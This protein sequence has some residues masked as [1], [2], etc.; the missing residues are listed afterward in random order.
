[1]LLTRKPILLTAIGTQSTV[2]QADSATANTIFAADTDSQLYGGGFR[3]VLRGGKGNDLLFGLDGNDTLSGGAGNDRLDGG[4]GNDWLDGG[5]GNDVLTG[6]AGRDSFAFQVNNYG[7][8]VNFSKDIGQDVVT[9]FTSGEDQIDLTS[10]FAR[11]KDADVQDII[12][13]LTIAAAP[14]RK[15]VDSAGVSD[16]VR[17]NGDAFGLNGERYDF[18]VEARTDFARNKTVELWIKNADDGADSGALIRFQNLSGFKAT[19]FLRET[20]K[21]AQG[22]AAADTLDYSTLGGNKGV[23]VYGFAGDD[24]LIGTANDDYFFGDAGADTIQGGGGS[25]NLY[26]SGSGD[27]LFGDGGDD[28]LYGGVNGGYIDGKGKGVGTDVLTGGAGRDTFVFGGKVVFD[29]AGNP[30]FVFDQGATVITDFKAGEDRIKIANTAGFSGNLKWATLDYDFDA[31]EIA[32]HLTVG[33]ADKND[34]VF[35]DGATKYLLDDFFLIN[36]GLTLASV[37]AQVDLYFTFA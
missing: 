30:N 8:S 2:I 14:L 5:S 22:T 27:R 28:F 31:K 1:M 3:D 25:D 21:I 16:P 6:G 7:A 9:D 37:K 15:G 11:F 34:L 19:D 18:Q 36:K 32:S 29:G 24:K 12:D 33:T 26:G 4:T 20:V 17:I 35:T 10:V 23:K 13:A